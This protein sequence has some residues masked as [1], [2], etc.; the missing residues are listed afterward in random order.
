MAIILI[1]TV[2]FELNAAKVGRFIYFKFKF[3]AGVNPTFVT[4]VIIP[5]IKYPEMNVIGRCFFDLII[6]THVL[7]AT[8][9]FSVILKSNLYIIETFILRV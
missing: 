6:V 4:I 9:I 3:R 7:T 1:F 2:D 8:G 5:M